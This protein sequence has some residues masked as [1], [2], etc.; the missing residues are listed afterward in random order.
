MAEFKIIIPGAWEVPEHISHK[1]FSLKVP[2]KW[3]QVAKSLAEKRVKVLGRGYP[4]VPVYSLDPIIAASF[5]Q[6]IKTVRYG[7]Q[8]SGIPWIFSTEKADLS[9]LPQII[10]DWLREEFYPSLGEEEVDK[11][12]NNLD[13]NW[14]WDNS[15][16]DTLKEQLSNIDFQAIPDYLATKFLEN[17]TVTFGEHNQYELKFY[18]V[19]KLQQGAELMSWPPTPVTRK[20]EV[21][22][23]SFVISFSLQ[24]IPWRKQPIIY[25]QLSIRRWITKKF[26]EFPYKGATVYVGDIRRWLDGKR[27]PFSFIPL[28]LK[29]REEKVGFPRAISELL[30]M[31]DSQL[32]DPENLRQNL[33]YKWSENPKGIQA[34]IAYDNRHDAH[35]CLPGV[36]PLDL[37]SLDNTIQ[38]KLDLKR[39]GEAEKVKEKA[40]DF[41][42]KPKSKKK[43]DKTPKDPND[44]S[45]PMLRPFLAQSAV[46]SAYNNLTILIV[47]ETEEC[48]NALINEIC[49]LLSL[50]KIGETKTQQINNSEVTETLYQSSQ[51][52]VCIKTQHV[53]DLTQ[54][55]DIKGKN[56]RQQRVKLMEERINQIKSFLPPTETIAGA[57]VE[58]KEPP[59]F[60]PEKDPKLAWRIG[61]RQAGYLNQHI[62]RLTKINKKGEK[63]SLKSPENRV[64]SAVSDL[65]RQFGILPTPLIKPEL[66][67]IEPSIWLTCVYILRRTRK[68]TANNKANTVGLILRVNPITGKVELTIP[69]LF[70]KQKNSG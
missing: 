34:A 65:F 51:A 15:E 49:Q 18:R 28:Q 4:S 44:S 10:K 47:W 16:N 12:L 37:A 45:T 2:S 48:R 31:N 62:H 70:Y 9:L 38:T 56:K 55:F 32:P 7:W 53:S 67:K 22:Y 64:K 40:V 54:D 39:V 25:H 24:T 8:K 27:Q 46:F 20:K 69:S 21:E 1:P 43:G 11:C 61:A 68:T 26:E 23:I 57:I 14:E 35:S 59:S 66:D 52:S 41:W 36:S 50:S 17:N 5:P 33:Q 3:Q 13:N 30:K 6:I 42:G 60:I 58:I 19:V 29:R 63:Y